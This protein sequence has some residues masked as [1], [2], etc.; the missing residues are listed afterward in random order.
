MG[1]T[2]ETA[3]TGVFRKEGEYWTI[4]YAGTV[5]RLRDA[6]GIGYLAQLLC[7]PGEKL[8]AAVVFG[9]VDPDPSAPAPDAERARLAVTQRIKAA[10]RKIEEHHPMLAGHLTAS[11]KTGYSCGYLPRPGQQIDWQL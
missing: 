7:H 9:A 5:C 10:L 4:A 2:G 8:A 6:K 1:P 11:I 3:E